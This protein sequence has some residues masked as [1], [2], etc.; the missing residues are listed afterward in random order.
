MAVTSKQIAEL[1]GVSRGTVDRALHGRGRVS[2]EVAAR[3]HRIA[4]ELDY[5]PNAIGRA[6]V[7]AS[8]DLKIGVILQSVETPTVQTVSKGVSQAASELK[9]RGIALITHEI[10]GL[11]TD[12]VLRAIDD[13]VAQGISG[14]A[15]SA[16]SAPALR[17]RIDA[18]H[19]D[20][21]PVITLNSDAPDSARICFIGMDNYRAG[22][23]AAGL[24]RLLLPAGGKVFPLTGHPGSTAHNHRLSGFSD[25]L[26]AENADDI[27]LLPFQPCFDRDDFA[28]EITQHILS[29]HPDLAGIYVACNGQLGVCQAVRDA[30]KTGQVRVIAFDLT[31]PNDALLRNGSIS[32]VLDQDAFA[33]GYRPPLLLHDY[34]VHRQMPAKTLLYTDIDVCTKYNIGDSV[35][36]AR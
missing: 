24:M 17:Q 25:T 13:L 18:L 16:S 23:T 27:A 33:Q 35:A 28:Y 26:A 11:D 8:R 36:P 10:Q 21:I 6:L 12:A 7:S 5:Q 34:L 22:Q 2:P 14:L 29:S 4:E 20:G 30:C 31:A 15:L 19:A 3:I 32:I 1:A 9:S